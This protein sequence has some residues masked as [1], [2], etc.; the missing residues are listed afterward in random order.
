MD[1]LPQE[2]VESIVGYMLPEEI[3]WSENDSTTGSK[4]D[5]IAAYASLSSNFQHAVERITFRDIRIKSTELGH[6]KDAFQTKNQHRR[7]LLKGLYMAIIL[8][9]YGDKYCARVERVSDEQANND[10]FTE[11]IATL[12]DF[13]NEWISVGES[14]GEKPKILLDIGAVSSSDAGY[15]PQEYDSEGKRR[16]SIESIDDDIKAERWR[17]SYLAIDDIDKIKGV[18]C[19]TQFRCQ[20]Y[21]RS[22]SRSATGSRSFEPASVVKLATRMSQLEHMDCNFRDDEK[23]TRFVDARQQRR[24]GMRILL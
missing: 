12:F 11:A 5:G 4:V 19:I 18:Q 8:P 6:F 16:Y 23:W 7:V 3:C 14:T 1:R 21:P 17:R 9:E 20:Q 15:R 2:I 13:L 10:A 24:Y 22:S